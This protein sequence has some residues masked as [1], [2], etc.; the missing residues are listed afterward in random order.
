VSPEEA[1]DN[2]RSLGNNIGKGA[3]VTDTETKVVD[4]LVKAGQ[5]PNH[6]IGPIQAVDAGIRWD[7]EKT[8][9]FV[10]DLQDRKLIVERTEAI[11]TLESERPQYW[12]WE[13]AEG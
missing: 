2:E 12:W 5:S 9:R 4:I 7:T 13:R 11:N 3:L 8:K 10:R 6:W 1:C